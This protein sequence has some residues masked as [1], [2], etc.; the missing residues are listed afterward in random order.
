MCTK[1]NNICPNAKTCTL[2]SGMLAGKEAF[3][4]LFISTYCNAGEKQQKKC[5]R[6]IIKSI[7]GKCPPDLLPNSSLSTKQIAEKYKLTL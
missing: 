4:S 6:F 3:T 7:Y 1:E 5:K 2:Y